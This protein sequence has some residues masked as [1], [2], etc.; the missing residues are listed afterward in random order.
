MRIT[1]TAL[2][3]LLCLPV[4]AEL[5][6]GV[7]TGVADGDTLYVTD[8]SQRKHKIRLLGI[9]APEHAQTFGET[10]KQ[11]LK[12]LALRQPVRIEW[13][14]RDRYGRLLG[15]VSLA[16]G[17]D[18][19]LSQVAK[20]MAWWNRKYAYEQEAQ[21]AILYREAEFAARKQR[22]GL[23]SQQN[24]VPPWRWRYA[25]PRQADTVRP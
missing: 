20:G 9:D 22:S 17:Q 12:Q 4:Q 3:L 5:L 8:A 6:Q 11:S 2:L 21:D 16:N 14:H 19:G 10:A 1:F 13:Q 15:K 25:N 24:P 18:A 7:V 23:W